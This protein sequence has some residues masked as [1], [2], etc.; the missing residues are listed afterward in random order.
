MIK[1]FEEAIQE[2]DPTELKMAQ[3]L[4]QK[5]LDAVTRDELGYECT[6]IKQLNRNATKL[7][8]TP[9]QTPNPP[10]HLFRRNVQSLQLVNIV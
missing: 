7:L 10:A 8:A 4:Y 3:A 9:I 1:V 2:Q 6:K 5:H